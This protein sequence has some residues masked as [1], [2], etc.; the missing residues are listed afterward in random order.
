M[1]RTGL[2]AIA[3]SAALACGLAGAAPGPASA[4]AS[5]ARPG[6]AAAKHGLVDSASGIEPPRH[7]GSLRVAGTLRD[8]GKVRAAGV[9]WKPGR[10]PAGDKLL[11]F[12]VAYYW[13]S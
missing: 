3:T 5:A 12:A 8:G 1:R 4:A 13:R 11:S 10:L 9:R 7:S 6:A 2:L